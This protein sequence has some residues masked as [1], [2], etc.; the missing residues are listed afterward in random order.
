[1]VPDAG[2]RDSGA[3]DAVVPDGG[4]TTT[5]VAP[6][7]FAAGDVYTDECFGVALQVDGHLPP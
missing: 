6:L 3:R 2:T 5:P 7:I 1:V 4:S